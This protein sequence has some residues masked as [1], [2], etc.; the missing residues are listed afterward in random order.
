MFVPS[1]ATPTTST[2]GKKRA[3]VFTGAFQAKILATKTSTDIAGNSFAAKNPKLSPATANHNQSP[4]S[5]LTSG[6]MTASPTIKLSA[7]TVW[8][9]SVTANVVINVAKQAAA[10]QKIRPQSVL[11]K[12]SMTCAN[13]QSPAASGK[14]F[15]SANISFAT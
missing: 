6:I 3:N 7:A 2:E 8:L 11:P 9:F 5:P 13:I 4:R 14:T 10:T 1:A 12:R 15:V